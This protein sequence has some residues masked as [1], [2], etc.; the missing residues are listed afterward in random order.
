[1]GDAVDELLVRLARAVALTVQRKGDREQA[2]PAAIHPRLDCQ[3]GRQRQYHE[4]ELGRDLVAPSESDIHRCVLAAERTLSFPLLNV[5]HHGAVASRAL[6]TADGDKT[7][8]D[9]RTLRSPQAAASADKTALGRA[10]A[11]LDREGG[12]RR[13]PT[14]RGRKPAR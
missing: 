10:F 14:A 9:R 2:G 8:G 13:W 5:D 7:T 3:Q 11:R 1:M 4:R 6:D 12:C